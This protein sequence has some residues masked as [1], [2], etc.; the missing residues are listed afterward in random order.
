VNKRSSSASGVESRAHETL[1]GR[2]TNAP[3]INFFVIALALEHLR[4]NV[5]WSPWEEFMG[6]K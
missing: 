6:V 3:N 1:G 4:S 5:D 2:S